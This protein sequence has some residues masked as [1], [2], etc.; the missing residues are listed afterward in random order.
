MKNLLI[1]VFTALSLLTVS[2]FATALP[3]ISGQLDIGGKGV[4]SVTAEQVTQIDL[5]ETPLVL[6]ATGD[7]SS[8][9]SVGDVVT[10]PDP[11]IL[12]GLP[13][14]LWSVGGF[15]FLLENIS[16]N[17]VVNIAGTDFALV[18]GTGTI[19][20][21]GYENTEGSWTYSSQSN[22]GVFGQGE[23][24]FSSTTVPAPA[25]V[26]LL[27]IALVGFGITRRQRLMNKA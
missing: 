25:T 20:S 11:F 5:V 7:F 6:G 14:G 21:A 16:T 24:S 17:V 3:I 19:S 8:T 12:G 15:S 2:T 23:F 18:E 22:G 4:F 26:A 9:V 13:L 10:Y 1:S 27:G